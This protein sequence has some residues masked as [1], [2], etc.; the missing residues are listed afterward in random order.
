PKEN[1]T[2]VQTNV[3]QVVDPSP[4][5]G[6]EET[7]PDLNQN[8]PE[9]EAPTINE[10]KTSTQVKLQGTPVIEAS[11]TEGII[12]FIGQTTSQEPPQHMA[13]HDVIITDAPNA[14]REGTLNLEGAHSTS[15]DPQPPQVSQE[16]KAKSVEPT[17]S[18]DYEWTTRTEDSLA[19]DGTIPS[20]CLPAE[21]FRGVKDLAPE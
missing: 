20:I 11:N 10:D 14:E 6:I 9:V 8:K 19:D 5:K 15:D 12:P 16:N 1:E 7:K 2:Q 13:Q 17:L 3:Q 4:Q 21:I 18:A